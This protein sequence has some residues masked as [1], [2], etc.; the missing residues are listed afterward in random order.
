[1]MNRIIWNGKLVDENLPVVTASSRGL[2]YGDGLFETMRIAENKL[3]NASAHFTRLFHGMDL[4]GFE[5]PVSFSAAYLES[6][7]LALATQNAHLKSARVRLTI[8]RGE[9]GVADPES[10]LPNWLIQTT[11]IAPLSPQLPESGLTIGFFRDARKTADLYSSLKSNNFLAYLMAA[12][13]AKKANL[14]DAILMNP[15]DRVADTTIANIFWAEGNR[16]FTIPLSEGPIAGTARARLIQILKE[17]EIVVEETA[18]DSE[19]ILAADAVFLT[20][21]VTGIRWVASI[22][23]RNFEPGPAAEFYR[24]LSD[25]ND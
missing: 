22:E 17:K 8:Y 6:Q 5:Y 24:W 18:A 1:M 14:D 4:L 16:I 7:A 20:N 9:G 10:N 23:H 21:A 11:A 19:R 15:Y 3:L 12:Q 13:F 25:T 2:R